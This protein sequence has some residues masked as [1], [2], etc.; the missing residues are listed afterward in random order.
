MGSAPPFQ[1]EEYLLRTRSPQ[2]RDQVEGLTDRRW[3]S[4][5][6]LGVSAKKM[7]ARQEALIQRES[8]LPNAQTHRTHS[9]YRLVLKFLSPHILNLY[10][11]E[12]FESN[13]CL[14]AA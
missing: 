14:I 3:P 4:P 12:Y 6:N 2:Y 8:R 5:S 13:Q 10:Y 1:V 7:Q 11:I 9:T